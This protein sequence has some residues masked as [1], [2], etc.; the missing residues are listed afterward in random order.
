MDPKELDWFPTPSGYDTTPLLSAFPEFSSP[1]ELS[2]YTRAADPSQWQ[3]SVIRPQTTPAA[4]PHSAAAVRHPGKGAKRKRE[5]RHNCIHPGCS[6]LF[7]SPKDLQ[8][9]VDA[10]HTLGGELFGCEF[11]SS[12]MKRK[13]N[14]AK[15]MRSKHKLEDTTSISYVAE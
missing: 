8:R 5:R 3:E 7:V 9:H 1:G 10:R 4:P 12:K 13:D 2:D 6:W 15:H 11:C 14:L